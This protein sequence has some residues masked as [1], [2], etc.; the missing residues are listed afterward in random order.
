MAAARVVAGTVCA[1]CIPELLAEIRT[2]L[3]DL[4]RPSLVDIKARGLR[5]RP[6]SLTDR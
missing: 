1:D 4:D 3:A 5:R 6:R 2:R